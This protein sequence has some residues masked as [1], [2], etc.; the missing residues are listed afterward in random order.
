MCFNHAF[1]FKIDDFFEK[2]GV[3]FKKIEREKNMVLVK[4]MFRFRK[5]IKM[6]SKNMK[7]LVIMLGKEL[8]S[9][10]FLKIFFLEKR[11]FMEGRR[12]KIAPKWSNLKNALTQQL[13]YDEN[14]SKQT[15]LGVGIMHYC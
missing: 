7:F 3:F 5:R 12:C 14:Q 13:S 15:L 4:K 11:F 10:I 2:T 9:S 8:Y 1:M 6:K